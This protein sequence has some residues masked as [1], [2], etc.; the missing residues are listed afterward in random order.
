MTS[1]SHHNSTQ[2][3]HLGHG[4]M[5]EISRSVRDG[6]RVQLADNAC[7]ITCLIMTIAV[8]DIREREGIFKVVRIGGV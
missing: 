4:E 6:C 1:S 2:S 8:C 7:G 3:D 5:K